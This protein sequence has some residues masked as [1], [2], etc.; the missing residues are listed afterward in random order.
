MIL[1]ITLSDFDETIEA[2]ALCGL[3]RDGEGTNEDGHP[4]ARTDIQTPGKRSATNSVWLEM[5]RSSSLLVEESMICTE[6]A[7]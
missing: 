6:Y 3:V 5:V 4:E 2:D 7:I 1:I